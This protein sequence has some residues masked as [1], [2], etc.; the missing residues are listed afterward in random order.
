V[1]ISVHSLNNPHK[2]TEERKK[3][4]AISGTDA[5]Q[6]MLHITLCKLFGVLQKKRN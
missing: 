3:V 2:K 6:A 4:I 5:R 1:Q